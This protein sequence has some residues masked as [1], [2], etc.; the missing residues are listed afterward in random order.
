MAGWLRRTPLNHPGRNTT[1]MAFMNLVGKLDG[2]ELMQMHQFLQ[3]LPC[4]KCF[5]SGY[6]IRVVDF[7]GFAAMTGSGE[8][9]NC[10]NGLGFHLVLS[11]Q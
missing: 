11:S 10:C 7:F 2:E 9:C 1:I 8:L 5:S 3:T 4:G 6:D